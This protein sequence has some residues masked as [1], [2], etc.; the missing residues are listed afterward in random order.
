MKCEN[1]D[2]STVY[3]SVTLLHASFLKTA[4]HICKVT[5]KSFRYRPD[6]N[7]IYIKIYIKVCN[8]IYKSFHM[9]S[10]GTAYPA[11]HVTAYPAWHVHK[12]IYTCTS[13]YVVYSC[14]C[15]HK[16]NK[17]KMQSL[18]NNRSKLSLGMLYTAGSAQ[19][20]HTK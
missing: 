18:N 15:K 5:Q 7:N 1:K 12:Y 3:Y 10:A 16:C 11:W 14:T 4:M 20:G 13:I 8:N 19:P 9:P 2:C 17:F 6:C